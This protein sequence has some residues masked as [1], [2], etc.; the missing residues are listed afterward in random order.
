MLGDAP[1][2]MGLGAGYDC[3]M[4]D[5]LGR[6]CVSPEGFHTMTRMLLSQSAK[7]VYVLEGGY[8]VNDAADEPHKALCAGVAQTLEAMLVGGSECAEECDLLSQEVRAETKQL[9]EEALERAE[10][11]TWWNTK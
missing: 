10:T 6:F 5:P 4:G 1:G 3:G 2:C 11:L 8:D 9:I 7:T